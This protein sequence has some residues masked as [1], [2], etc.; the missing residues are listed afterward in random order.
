[1]ITYQ[2]TKINQL[3][4]S[5]EHMAI[6]TVA[7]TL[8]EE[9]QDAVKYILSY[10]G[11]KMPYFYLDEYLGIRNITF[12]YCPPVVQKKGYGSYMNQQLKN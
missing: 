6:P 4:L 5:L 3:N 7:S 1:M 10:A 9:L 12:N 8:T 2:N 11:K